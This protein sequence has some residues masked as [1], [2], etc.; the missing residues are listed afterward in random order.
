[1]EDHGRVSLEC[2][3]SWDALN[4]HIGRNGNGKI[5]IGLEMIS[6]EESFQIVDSPVRLAILSSDILDKAAY[7]VIW[8]SGTEDE[9]ERI[10]SFLNEMKFRLA[11]YEEEIK[12]ALKKK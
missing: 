5:M 11:L 4:W 8:I 6:D 1:M 12:S 2:K 7:A 9:G 3:S 10:L